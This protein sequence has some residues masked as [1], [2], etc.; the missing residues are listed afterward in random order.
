[1]TCGFTVNKN[2]SR[3]CITQFDDEIWQSW[4][5]E[6]AWQSTNKSNFYSRLVSLFQLCSTETTVFTTSAI[7]WYSFLMIAVVTWLKYCIYGVKLFPINQS[8]LHDRILSIWSSY[9]LM[10]LSINIEDV[11]SLNVHVQYIRSSL[12]EMMSM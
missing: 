7:L 5:Q 4:Y 9:P 3:T 10:Q 6:V 11:L 1:M 12:R 8:V 2:I